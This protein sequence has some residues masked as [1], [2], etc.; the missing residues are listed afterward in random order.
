MSEPHKKSG[1]KLWL[2]LLVTLVAVLALG[3]MLRQVDWQQAAQAGARVPLHVWLLSA[4]GMAASHLL[5]AGRVRDHLVRT[6]GSGH[7]E[8]FLRPGDRVDDQT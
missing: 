6:N 8:L 5:R 1:K 2:S 4:L 3:W 7:S